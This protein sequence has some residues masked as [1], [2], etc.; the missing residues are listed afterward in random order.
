VVKGVDVAA[1]GW[2]PDWISLG[3][4]TSSVP[5]DVVDEVIAETGKSAK[6]AGGKLPPHVMVYYPLA[7]F[8]DDDYEEVAARLVDT[9]LSWRCWDDGW[10][11]P[12]SGGITQARQRLGWQPLAELFGRVGV[13]VAQELTR[14]VGPWRLMSIDG[15]EWDAPDS[16]ENVAAFGY[17]ATG[18]N[19]SAFAKVRVVT[20]AECASHAVVGAAI[21]A[22]GQGEQTLARTLY[23]GLD[24]DWLLIADR[25][26]YSFADWNAARSGGAALLWRVKADPT[27]PVLQI[28]PD[29]SYASVLVNPKVRGKARDVVLAAARAGQDLDADKA[30]AVR[31]VEYTVPDRVGDGTGERSTV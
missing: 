28:W 11:V 9:L 12:T 25:N 22:Q 5:R 8:A 19:A 4:L 29:G 17:A 26:F 23:P 24:E 16:V 18:D 27:L 14:G 3:V 20:V 1:G 2:L 21:G 6:R 10:S 13:P 15:F 30:V 7:L 31:V